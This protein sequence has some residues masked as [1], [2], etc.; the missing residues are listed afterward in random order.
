DSNNRCG[1]LSK[2][3]S[4]LR[5]MEESPGGSVAQT[6]SYNTLI[7]G[8]GRELLVDEAFGVAR[9]MLDKGCLPDEVKHQEAIN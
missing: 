6:L 2:A 3:R 8:L 7:K 4:V 5:S 1:E 9:G